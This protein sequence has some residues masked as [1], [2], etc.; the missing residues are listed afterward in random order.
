[1]NNHLVIDTSV[2]LTYAS[3]GK[4]YRLKNA[5]EL[6]NLT[7]FVCSELLAEIENN[8]PKILKVD[9]FTTLELIDEI[10]S[11]S[12][13]IIIEKNYNKSPDPKDN[14]LFDVALQSDSEIIVTQEKALLAF[15]TS[16]VTIHNIKW[17]KETIL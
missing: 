1:M 15:Q 13:L 10:R 4:I 3:F 14:F 9:T 11:F 17:F 2:F 8:L 7:V 16:P 5:I 6:Y 12:T